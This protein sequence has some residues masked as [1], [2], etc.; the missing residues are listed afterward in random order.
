MS[1]I[2]RRLLQE[3][4]E[5]TT[6]PSDLSDIAES[7]DCN[8]SIRIA[9]LE[10]PNTN[11]KT[12]KKIILDMKNSDLLAQIAAAPGCND[13]IR[14]TLLQN[15]HTNNDTLEKALRDISDTSESTIIVLHR[16]R[17]NDRFCDIRFFEL[18]RDKMRPLRNARFFVPAQ[19]VD[20]SSPYLTNSVFPSRSA[21]V[22]NDRTD[23]S[24][25][26]LPSPDVP[27]SLLS[28]KRAL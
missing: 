14:L 27:I 7:P 6:I 24:S 4:A 9:I 18:L 28:P 5:D 19:Y 10:N 11:A 15:P 22:D 26:I 13:S 2:R 20:H 8:D 21:S 12:Q 25:P 16:L 3:L 23:I 17:Q 1:K